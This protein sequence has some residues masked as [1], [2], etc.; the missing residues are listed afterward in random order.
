MQDKFQL[1]LAQNTFVAKK[2]LVSQIYHI[3]RFENCKTTLLQTEKIIQN[4]N[5]AGVS[6]DDIGVIVALKRGFEFVFFYLNTCQADNTLPSFNVALMCR[7]NGIV[8]VYDA[9]IPGVLRTGQVGVT[10]YDGSRHEPVAQTDSDVARYLETLAN[11]TMSQTERA[12]RAMLYMMRSQLFWD[13]NKRTAILFANAWLIWHGCGVL[14]IDE[15]HFD[16]FNL[17][18]SEY[19]KT[20]DMDEILLFIHRHCIQGMTLA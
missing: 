15:V 19:Y 12:L 5:D 6:L 9:L 20:G 2:R 3:S 14:E 18:L 10:L 7:I 11:S 16:E 1:T 17:K 8:A 13:G 4:R